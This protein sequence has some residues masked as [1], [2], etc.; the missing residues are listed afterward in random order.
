MEFFNIAKEN[1]KKSDKHIISV[2]QD[3]IV[4]AGGTKC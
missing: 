4:D 1:N 2:L 3:A